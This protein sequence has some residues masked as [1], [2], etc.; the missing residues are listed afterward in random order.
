MEVQF[1]KLLSF[2]CFSLWKLLKYDVLLSSR[3]QGERAT[4]SQTGHMGLM[5][6]SDVSADVPP[7]P[8]CKLAGKR[9]P[10]P[11]GLL[12]GLAFAL[13][14]AVGDPVC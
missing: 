12:H 9:I 11:T 4:V 7:L 13:S 8:S 14:E 3:G 5:Q 2:R 10:S 6:T 1:A